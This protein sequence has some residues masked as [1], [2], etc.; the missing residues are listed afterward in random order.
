VHREHIREPIRAYQQQSRLNERSAIVALARA[1]HR[2]QT[3]ST[4]TFGGF[5]NSKNGQVNPT[6]HQRKAVGVLPKLAYSEPTE[7]PRCFAQSVSWS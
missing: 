5:G 3:H 7:E 6:V 4:E 2:N 1:S